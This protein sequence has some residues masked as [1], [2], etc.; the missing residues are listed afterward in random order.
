MKRKNETGQALVFAAVGLVVLLGFVGLGVDMGTLR[1]EKRLQQTA[2]DAAAIAGASNL[3][4]SGIQTG[5]QTASS[6]NGFTD[7]TGG[8][9]C[10]PPPT[11]LAVGSITVTLCNAPITGPH[12]GDNKYVEAYVSAGQPTYFMKI[13]GISSETITA[14]AVATNYSGAGGSTTGDRTGCLYTL[15]APTASIE[16]VSI[17]GAATLNAPTCGILDNGNYN[18]QGNKLIVNADTFGVSGSGIVKG[19]GGDVTCSAGT[20]TCPTYGTPATSDPMASIAPPCS[21]CTGGSAVS[22]KG[23]GKFTGTGV[24]YSNGTYTVQPGNYTS[25][26]ITGTGGGNNVVFAPGTYIFD[27]NTG[28][29]ADILN[30]PGNATITGNGVTFYFTNHATIQMNGTP[31]INLTPPSSGAYADI[32]LWQDKNDTNVGPAPNGPT[33]GGNSGSKYNGIL[34][35]PSDQLTFYGNNNSVSVGVV[36]SDSLSLSGSPV[37]NFT[38]TPGLPGPLP[39]GSTFGIGRA[40]LVE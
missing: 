4:Y 28:T 34:Y 39:P 9:A 21:P 40:F 19:P 36:V 35:F 32:L 27:G 6:Q 11:S 8:G 18:S 26:S 1:Y 16:G 37:V 15:G 38:G 29:N 20:T 24:T 17:N 7:N 23:N 2:A 13:F 14:R 31:T 33:L 5:A 12:T 30:I 25:F 22:I 10:A 3:G